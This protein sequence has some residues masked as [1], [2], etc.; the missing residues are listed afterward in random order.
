[1]NCEATRPKKFSQKM[2][3]FSIFEAV[4]SRRVVDYK[5]HE[6]VG[7]AWCIRNLAKAQHLERHT[8]C[9]NT[10]TWNEDGSKLASGSDDRSIVVWGGYP[11]EPIITVPTGHRN[12]V[13]CV[14]FIP[15]GEDS[16]FVTSAADGCV[17]L[18]N[19]DSGQRDVLFESESSSY[20]F[21]H[22]LD[23]ANPCHTGLVT[24]SD[25]SVVRFDLRV[26]S[27]FEILNV[28]QDLSL[29]QLSM[30]RFTS[31][32][33]GTAIAFNPLRPSEFALGTSTQAVLLFDSRNL[34]YPT[35]KVVPL[36]THRSADHHYPGETEAVSGLEWDRRN[37]LIVN[38]CRQ[39]VIELD[40]GYLSSGQFL[41]GESLAI[42]R[43]WSGRVNHQTFL[44][45]VALVGDGQYVATGGDCGNLYIW[46]RFGNQRLVVKKT[47]DPYVLNCVAPHPFLPL[48]ATSGIASVADVWGPCLDGL[49]EADTGSETDWSSESDTSSTFVLRVELPGGEANER[50]G[51]ANVI[52]NEGNQ[53]FRAGDFFNA[54]IKYSEVCDLL[55]FN[56]PD[57][58]LSAQRREALE[59]GLTN[60]AAA[61]M[62]LSRW[63]E[64]IDAC[65][66]AIDLN[67][68]CAK[69][70]LRR[71]KCYA[72]IGDL[73]LALEDI[74]RVQVVAPADPEAAELLADVQARMLTHDRGLLYRRM[75]H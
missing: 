72:R 73:E 10:I 64:A 25:G 54:L 16:T 43:Q 49:A 53:S 33:S 66:E 68:S 39:S 28:R 35:S 13:F 37:R 63:T 55:Q 20:C 8:G 40:T 46:E 14:T 9:I 38:Y 45:E 22:V 69:A 41:V 19:V 51:R 1:M 32:P 6:L 18:L 31:A 36:F 75:F 62:G 15:N 47:A 48:L 5:N 74:Q 4:R 60:K 56:C 17:H 67:P 70:L 21:K 7:G 42:P 57:A 30:G 23:P 2:T 59:K 50:L 26:K 24:L 71:A 12:N 52:R 65:D 61:L 11:F 3:N 27:G 34:S 44:K 58:A 29:R